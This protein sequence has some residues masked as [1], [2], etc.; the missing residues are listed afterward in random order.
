[1]LYSLEVDVRC[2]FSPTFK[3]C[4]KLKKLSICLD[5]ADVFCIFGFFFFFTSAFCIVRAM[6]SALRLMNSIFINEQ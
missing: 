1:M 3:W 2:Q 6:N 4:A 5:W